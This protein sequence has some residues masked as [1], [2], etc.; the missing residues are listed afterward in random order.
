MK[1][2]SQLTSDRSQ[3]PSL[4]VEVEGP[5]T[6]TLGKQHFAPIQFNNFEVGPFEVKLQPKPGEIYAEMQERATEIL[7]DMFNIEFE[8]SLNDFLDKM[9]RMGKIVQARKAGR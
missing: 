8:R 3:A 7:Q 6:F 2:R 5:T 4:S 1:K 9:V